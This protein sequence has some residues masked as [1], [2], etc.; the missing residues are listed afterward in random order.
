MNRPTFVLF[1]TKTLLVLCILAL[2]ALPVFAHAWYSTA[3]CSGKDCARVPAL[4]VTAG[5][6]G[7]HVRIRPG[8]HPMVT[9]GVLDAVVPYDEA[10]PS[11]DDGFHACVRD[12]SSPS[13]VMTDPIICLYVP[14]M[15]S[16]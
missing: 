6:D 12:Q 1:T 15:G 5:P 8:E 7:W 3:C 13:A 4:S 10:L 9:R 14:D 11:Q 16:A 2:M